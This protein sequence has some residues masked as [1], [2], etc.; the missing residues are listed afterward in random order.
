MEYENTWVGLK[1]KMPEIQGPRTMR[2][3]LLIF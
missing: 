3:K 2:S 1:N